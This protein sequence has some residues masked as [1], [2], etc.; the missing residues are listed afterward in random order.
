[1]HVRVRHWSRAAAFMLLLSSLAAAREDAAQCVLESPLLDWGKGTHAPARDPLPTLAATTPSGGNAALQACTGNREFRF[2]A[3]I[4]DITGPAGGKIMMGNEDPEH[5]ASGIYQ[6]NY[7]RAFVLGSPCNGKRVVMAVTDTGMLFNSVWQAVMDRIAADPELSAHYGPA[8]VMLSPT[9]THTAP[10]GYAH[11]T[12]YNAMRFGY[13]DQAFRVIVEGLF[14]AIRE[15][16]DNYEANPVRGPLQMAL[17]E[18]IDTAVSRARLAYALNPEAERQS[19]VDMQGREIVTNRLMTQLN[20][21]R[22]DGGEVGVINWFSVHATAA[23][24]GHLV[25]GDNKGYASYLFERLQGTDQ[26]A[27][28]DGFVAMFVQSDEGESWPMLYLYRE[29]QRPP[30]PTRPDEDYPEVVIS[31][32]KQLAR[33]IELYRDGGEPLTGG[34]DYR[35]FFVKMD[36]VNVTDPVVLE[37]LRHPP[38]MD[39]AEKRT[40]AAALGVSFPGGGFGGEDLEREFTVR[41][42]VSCRN[43][44]EAEIFQREVEAALAGKVPNELFAHAVGCNVK[45]VPGLNLQ[46]HAEKPILFVFG[47]PVNASANVVPFQLF[48]IGNLG[49]LALPWEI[50]TMS[51]RRIRALLGDVLAG[52]GIDHVVITGLANDYVQYLTTREEYA[53]QQYEGASNQFGPWTLAAVQQET[54]RLAMSLRDGTP[55]PPG[56]QPPRTEPQL[57]QL[58]PPGPTDLPGER[59]FGA[60]LSDVEPAYAPGDAA[61]AVFQT[62]HPRADLRTGDSFLF[63]ERRIRGDGWEVVARD[64]DPETSF[65]WE[66]DTVT[67]QLTPTFTS[68]ARI[69]WRIPNNVRPGTYRIRHTGAARTLPEGPVTQF[70][71]I[72]SEFRV[73]GRRAACP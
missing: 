27:P 22:D 69:V 38:E 67:A 68:R 28:D 72:S 62:G 18:L 13:D 54:R 5:F 65:H 33:S 45:H 43:P 34:I 51:G 16:H 57:I 32:T 56:P 1:M 6:R 70:E 39:A 66:P 52:A 19:Y 3:G 17:S 42:G 35:Q 14:K 37:S 55:A 41:S 31:G 29:D 26:D 24:K 59:G 23:H 47:P 12:A 73:A 61:V 44:A 8:N 10:G 60:L 25:S 46:C 48:A 64:R 50:T 36:E 71:G 49:V 30:Y 2:A 11:Y 40:C 7:A 58:F 4:E 15:A 20:L 53:Y 9:H 63:V 21:R